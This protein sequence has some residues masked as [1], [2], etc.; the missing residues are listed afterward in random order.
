VLQR[1]RQGGIQD[2]LSIVIRLYYLLQMLPWLAFAFLLI[3]YYFGFI[4][5]TALPDSELKLS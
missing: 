5:W 3:P 2:G 1:A 4:E